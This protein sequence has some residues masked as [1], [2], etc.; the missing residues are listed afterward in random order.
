MLKRK[1]LRKMLIT[2]ITVFIL[3]VVYLI[4]VKETTKELETNLEIEYV[5][6]LGTNFIYLFNDNQYLV[7]A[8]ILLTSDKLLDQVAQLIENLTGETS[9]QLPTGLYT[10]IP[11]EVKVVNIEEKDKIVTV[12]FSKEFLDI[13]KEIEEKV[14]EAIVYSIMDLGNVDG[15]KILVEGSPLLQLP[16]SKVTLPEVLTKKIGINK[17]YDLQNRTDI[18]KVV[19]YYLEEFEGNQYYVPVTKYVNDK[20]DKIKIIVDNLTSAYIY[21]P[22]L[23]SFLNR[24]TEL[25]DYRIEDNLMILN[26]NDS[27]FTDESQILEEVVYSLAYSVF[28]NYDVNEVVLQVNNQEIVKKTIN[29]LE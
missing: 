15:V 18:N 5:T 16:N 24:D 6:G 29:T 2:T 26:F 19:I 3:L 23:M 14:V 27:I 4:P 11:S 20:R 28:D 1:A 17:V 13:D 7:R 10:V 21:E 12:D 22:N 25:L 9:S 8:R